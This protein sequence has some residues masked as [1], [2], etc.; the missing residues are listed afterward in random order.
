MTPFSIFGANGFL[1]SRLVR[2]LAARGAEVLPITRETW[3]APGS[4]LGHAIFAIGMTADFRQKPLETVQSQ[5]NLVHRALSAYRFSSF[6]YLS[7]TRLYRHARNT[8]EEAPIAIEPVNPDELYNAAKLAGEAL[9]LAMP[10]PHFRV[11]RL[12]NL[13]GAPSPSPSFLSSVLADA[14]RHRRVIFRTRPESAKDYLGVEDAARALIAIAERGRERLYN[15]AS[16]EN[17]RNGAIANQLRALGIACDFAPDT[18]LTSFPPI[19]VTRLFREFPFEP[20]P[21]LGALPDL[22]AQMAMDPPE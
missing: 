8:A 16:G 7:S 17:T 9:V 12:S 11:A 14:V 5:V 19:N 15:V 22:L 1:G 4:D 20:V 21:L 13:F 18:A 10:D 3:P 2:Q 6:L